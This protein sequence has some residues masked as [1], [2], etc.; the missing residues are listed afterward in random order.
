MEK[1][2]KKLHRSGEDKVFGGVCGG[3]GEHFDID[4]V[5]VRVLFILLILANWAGIL[6]YAILWVITP[7]SHQNLDK[8][9]NNVS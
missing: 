7:I 9:N 2:S 8:T 5:L 1:T 6:A 4:P 3:L